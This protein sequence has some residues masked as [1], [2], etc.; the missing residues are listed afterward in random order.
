MKTTSVLIMFLSAALAPLAFAGS[1]PSNEGKSQHRRVYVQNSQDSSDGQSD[2][3]QD[4]NNT[5]PVPD[6]APADASQASP[7]YSAA[8]LGVT[9]RF[10]EILAEI[11]KAVDDGKLSNEDGKDL[12]IEA[13]EKAQMQFELLG[14]LRAL[15][16]N[17]VTPD[18]QDDNSPSGSESSAPSG[19]S[20]D[21]PT[22][23]QQHV[24]KT[25]F[26][27]PRKR[28]NSAPIQYVSVTQPQ[29]PS[30]QQVK[31]S[32]MNRLRKMIDGNF[33][34]GGWDRSSL[35]QSPERGNV[36]TGQSA[37]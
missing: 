36:V 13:Y 29:A 24:L 4:S 10:S 18:T 7:D 21:G 26:S 2:G 37:N 23:Q 32:E 3:Q 8:M 16:Q 19:S 25:T 30:A 35:P 27:I 15:G 31:G 12:S 5:P 28:I 17:A 9:Q 14:T 11:A 34:I 6:V 1:G 20:E 33:S 22:T